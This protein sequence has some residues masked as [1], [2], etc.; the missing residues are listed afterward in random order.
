M[1]FIILTFLRRYNDQ[2]NN[3][4]IFN[5]KQIQQFQN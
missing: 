5:H 2:Y 4:I 3:Q 1:W